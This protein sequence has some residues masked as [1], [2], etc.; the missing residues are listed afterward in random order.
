MN[1]KSRIQVQVIEQPLS[2]SFQRDGEAV[3]SV[4]ISDR[5]VNMEES[6]SLVKIQ[7][8]DTSLALG[9]FDDK[10]SFRFS[11]TAV[12]TKIEM[13]GYWYGIGQLVHQHWLVNKVRLP[14]SE[15]ITSDA[16]PTGYSNLMS[17][18]WLSDGGIVVIGRSHMY[19][20]IN[21]FIEDEKVEFEYLFGDEVPFEERPRMDFKGEGDGLLTFEGD[22]LAF[23]VFFG[24]GLLEA[25]KSLVSE[26]GHPHSTPPLELFGA[27]VW[28]TW[29]QYKD[30]I[31]Q[32][33]VL[34][35]AR[36]IREHGYPGQVIEIDDRWQVQYG[37]LEFD[38]ERFPDPRGMVDELH[39]MGFK[40]TTWVIPFLHKASKAGAEAVEKGYLAKQRDGS[41]YLVRWW[42]GKAYL[43]DATNREAMDWFGQNLRRLQDQV[44]LDGFKFD[45]GEASYV[46]ADALLHRQYSGRNQ[47]SHDYVAWIAEEFSFCETRTGWFNQT[48][49]LLF[50]LWDLWSVWSHANGLR[51]V[52]PATLSLSLTGYPFTFPDMIGGNG[53]FMF[54]KSK[55]LNALI[56]KVIIPL[57]ERGK[58]QAQCDEDVGVHASDV[59]AI[60]AKSPAFGWPTEELIIRWTQLN[61]LM[62]VMQFSITPWS[63]GERCTRICRKY[64]DLHLEFTPLFQRL[65]EKTATDGTP[66]VLPVFWLAPDDPRALECDNEFL[67][68]EVLLVAPV[69]H[70]GQRSRDI[71]L[72]P[73][74]WR[75][76]W[77]GEVYAGPQVLKAFPAPLERLPFFHA[78]GEEHV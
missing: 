21:Q 37:D 61:A 73:G 43:L 78:E 18:I 72:P 9:F 67:I 2:I 30:L 69:V 45:G 23:D 29:A 77:S 52:I 75:C 60:V 65:A 40:V 19:T 66:V 68:G 46:P 57:I 51:A 33:K 62:P 49:P 42:Q 36:Q 74:R 71:Y 58:Q 56:Q 22:D 27:P 13:E 48:A 20:G 24:D 34:D 12:V 59:P 28:T 16:G 14:L 8:Q 35:F 44:G 25:H 50:R 6:E 47:Y 41:P 11:G 7:S 17:P 53:Y 15:L 3:L 38:P 63:F 32:E 5:F 31:D 64:A 39:R 55:L 4:S 70:K 54:P 10:A 26:V 1:S 76:H